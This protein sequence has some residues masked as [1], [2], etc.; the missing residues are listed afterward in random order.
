[1]ENSKKCEKKNHTDYISV[2]PK[3]PDIKISNGKTYITN[4]KVLLAQNL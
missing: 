4:L 3:V 1:M 2:Y